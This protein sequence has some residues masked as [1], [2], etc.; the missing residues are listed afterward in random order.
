MPHPQP[1]GHSPRALPSGCSL[2]HQIGTSPRFFHWISTLK[3]RWFFVLGESARTFV[4]TPGRSSK[5]ISSN[6]G[7]FVVCHHTVPWAPLLLVHTTRYA[8]PPFKRH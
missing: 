2:P 8:S 5:K 7:S 4:H 1:L 3:R 6:A